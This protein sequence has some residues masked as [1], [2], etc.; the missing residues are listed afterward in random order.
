M[1][2]EI[3]LVYQVTNG[4]ESPVVEISVLGAGVRDKYQPKPDASFVREFRGIH[5]KTL[6]GLLQSAQDHIKSRTG[7]TPVWGSGVPITDYYL[8]KHPEGPFGLEYG[9]EGSWPL[10]GQ[11]E[12]QR[13]QREAEIKDR[14]TKVHVRILPALEE[15]ASINKF[16]QV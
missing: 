8:R 4:I 5:G 3:C 2:E 13:T 10:A 7:D 14:Y 15:F 16:Q 1:P 12:E 9:A 11:S 6:V